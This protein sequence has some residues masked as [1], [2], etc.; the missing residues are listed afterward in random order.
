LVPRIVQI[1]GQSA[2]VNYHNGQ[3]HSVLTLDVGNGRI[4]AIYIV[5]NP[6]K[7][8]HLPSAPK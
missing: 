4:K 5:T 8:V 7:L 1:N 6:E 2:V 3:P